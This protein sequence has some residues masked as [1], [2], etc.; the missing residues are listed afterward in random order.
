[1]T[2]FSWKKEDLKNLLKDINGVGEEKCFTKKIIIEDLRSILALMDITGQ[3]NIYAVPIGNLV[4]LN[5]RNPES[6]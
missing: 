5:G 2:V 1:M 4:Y 3:K 6:I